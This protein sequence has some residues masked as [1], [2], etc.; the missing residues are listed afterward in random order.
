MGACMQG[1]LEEPPII[2]LG[3]RWSW[4]RFWSTAIFLLALV[5]QLG[6]AKGDLA[7]LAQ[8]PVAWLLAI[9]FGL[10]VTGTVWMLVSPPELELSPQGIRRTIGWRTR[11]YGWNEIGNFKLVGLPRTEAVG[12]DYAD[13]AKANSGYRQWMRA[14]YG[15]A[16]F[17]ASNMEMSSAELVGLLN[18]ARA[19]WASAEMASTR[20]RRRPDLFPTLL[21]RMMAWLVGRMPRRD[22]WIGIGLV[23]LSA[24]VAAVVLGAR[25]A[26]ATWGFIGWTMLST[27]RLRD[28]GRSPLWLTAMWPPIGVALLA[29][30]WAGYGFDIGLVLA[31][32]VWLAIVGTL[33]A[34][35]GEVGRNRFGMPPGAADESEAI[36]SAF[37]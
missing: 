21:G 25:M 3:Q 14:S 19:R 20:T 36:G 27:G 10:G 23:A 4:A 32:V 16:G 6:V 12:F 34:L 11:R 17:L 1:S 15:A 30:I 13:P 22:Y 35:P 7:R 28:L 8:Q 26:A 18:R 33:G 37:T 31:A 2:V 29:P 24:T 9:F 5:G